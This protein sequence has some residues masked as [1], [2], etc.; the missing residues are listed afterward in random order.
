MLPKTIGIIPDGNR[1]LAKRLLKEPWKGHELGV[2]KLYTVLDWCRE[3]GV[4]TVTFYA[5]SLENIQKRPKEELEF[6]YHLIRKELD[7]I[8]TDPEHR[9]HKGQ[10]KLIFFGH[11]NLLPEDI[12]KKIQQVMERTKNHTG[13][14]VNFAMAYGGRQEILQAAQAL[15]DQ[16]RTGQ[17]QGITEES[18]RKQLQTNGYEDP[19]LILR[20]GGEKRLS[21]FLP[22]QSAY[23]ELA[24]IDTLW[25]DLTKEE[26]LKVL[27][28]F[29]NRDRRFGK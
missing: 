24:F 13:S 9:V 25:P 29:S 7:A 18:F 22:F 14:V 19:E 4:S 11:L 6:L 16:V 26:F 27:D 10:A 8:L 5:L 1:R 28:D 17:I 12:Q 23:A 20:T 15:A 3:A 2:G 21:N